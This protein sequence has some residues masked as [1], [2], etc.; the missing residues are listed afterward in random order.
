MQGYKRRQSIKDWTILFS[1][2]FTIIGAA[3]YYV[4]FFTPKNSLELYQAITFADDFEEVKK[5]NVKRVRR[6]F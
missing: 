3:T 6:Q 2:I 4:V 5:I 1:V